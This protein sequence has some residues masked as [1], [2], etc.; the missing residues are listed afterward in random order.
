MPALKSLKAS[1]WLFSV[2]LLIGL[3]VVFLKSGGRGEEPEMETIR[4]KFPKPMFVSTPLPVSRP[5][6]ESP[7]KPRVEFEAALESELISV[8]ARVTSSDEL[9][10]IGDLSLV[11][12]G[13]KCGSEGSYVELSYGKQWV[14]IDLGQQHELWAVLIWRIR[15]YYAYDDVIVQ[16]SSDPGFEE[17][18]FT[19][20]FNNDH[21]NSSGLGK[22]NDPA[23]VET[24]YGRIVETE[25]ITGRYIRLY[26]NG[27]TQNR[28]NHYSE[29]EVW[30]KP[31]LG[32][33][34]PLKPLTTK[35]STF[36]R[37]QGQRPQ[38]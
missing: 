21:D 14:Q 36:A 5:H 17:G 26:S 3:L 22:G 7:K 4:P 12:D 27:N 8:G 31:R 10:I 37:D 6:L 9:P 2:T 33:F 34:S 1:I 13:D 19:T 28:A 23:Y 16:I 18:T 35:L 15:P 24:N 30:G 38:P 29:V 25:G 32:L 11:T 20:V